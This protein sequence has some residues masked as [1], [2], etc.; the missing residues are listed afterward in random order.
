MVGIASNASATAGGWRRT[1]RKARR[2]ACNRFQ[3]QDLWLADHQRPGGEITQATS[4]A[5]EEHHHKA[6]GVGKRQKV[7][8]SHQ[9][10]DGDIE[11]ARAAAIEPDHARACQPLAG[12]LPMPAQLEDKIIA[13]KE[14]EIDQRINGDDQ[15]RH[16]AGIVAKFRRD[17]AVVADGIIATI[18][19]TLSRKS[20]I[21][22][23]SVSMSAPIKRL[24]MPAT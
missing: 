6:Q 12:R 17:G 7:D 20:R 21:A 18:T 2:R 24:P 16:P 14:A 5:V 9:V 13:P 11:K 23:A 3:V 10:A 8:Q 1:R 4:I 22:I 19:I 15:P